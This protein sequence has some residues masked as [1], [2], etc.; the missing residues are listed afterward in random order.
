M[1]PDCSEFRSQNVLIRRKMADIFHR[2]RSRGTT[3]LEDPV[4]PLERNLCGHPLAGLLC[5]TQFEDVLVELGKEKVTNWDCL[6]V[7]R[8]QRFFSSVLVDDITM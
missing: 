8:K 4:V 7:H 5:E 1:P 2:F 6:F 3:G